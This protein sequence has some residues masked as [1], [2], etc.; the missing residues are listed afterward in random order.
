MEDTGGI[1]CNCEESCKEKCCKIR[2]DSLKMALEELETHKENLPRIIAIIESISSVLEA[3][4]C[5]NRSCLCHRVQW[6]CCNLQNLSDETYTEDHSIKLD[7]L[8]SE[9]KSFITLDS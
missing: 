1:M 7:M 6:V 9:I 4:E 5:F 2:N 3:Y 8:I